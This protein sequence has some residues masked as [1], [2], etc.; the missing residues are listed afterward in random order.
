MAREVKSKPKQVKVKVTTS[1]SALFKAEEVTKH[2]KMAHDFI[3][4]CKGSF[5]IVAIEE[6]P[7]KK[8]GLN[9]RS[10][11]AGAGD[12]NELIHL[13]EEVETAAKNLRQ[14]LANEVLNSDKGEQ[15]DD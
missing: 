4:R 10:M 11:L 9:A 8:S 1:S 3:D 7:K 12:M 5:V 15:S 14:I 2:Q 6:H 13:A